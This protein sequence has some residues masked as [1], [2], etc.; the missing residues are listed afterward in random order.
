M[1]INYKYIFVPQLFQSN[2]SVYQ[3]ADLGLDFVTG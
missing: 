2:N 1:S 3:T